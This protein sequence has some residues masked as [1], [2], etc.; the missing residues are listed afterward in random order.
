MAVPDE[1]RLSQ[2]RHSLRDGQLDALVLLYPDD[3]LMAT[4]MLPGSTHVAA[5][6]DADGGVTLLTPWWRES[7]VG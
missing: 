7:F 3:I 2:I 1:E 5:I 4:G 6:V